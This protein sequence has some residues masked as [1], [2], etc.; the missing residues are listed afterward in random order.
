MV[1]ELLLG[2]N[3]FI[4]VSHLS[5]EKARAEVKE[6][7][8][9]NKAMVIEAAVE[10][11]ATG[12]TF[13]THESNLELL[14]YMNTHRRSVLNKLN[15]YILVPYAQAYVRK[16][17]VEGT[18]ALVKSMFKSMFSIKRS[19]ILDLL[20]AVTMLKPERLVDLFI[21]VELAPYLRVLPKENVKAVLLHEVLTELIIAYGLIDVVMR[22]DEKVKRRL[23]VSFGLETRNF[24]HLHQLILKSEYCPEYVMTPINSL[25]YQMAPSRDAVEGA[26]NDLGEKTDIIAINLLASGALCLDEAVNYVAKY[27]NKIY[28]V[29]SAST[30]PQRIYDN[31]RKLSHA[32]L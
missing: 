31:F 2:D 17:T 10:G 32:V 14:T 15:Y 7:T 24:G 16:G 25:G 29:T 30:K 19:S 23:G 27:K 4:G 12:F 21:E 8:V 9:E 1:E 6:A 20:Q 28:A 26:I 3:S 11:G 13:S 5:Q 22:L 18:P